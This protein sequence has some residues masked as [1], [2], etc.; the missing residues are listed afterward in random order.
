MNITYQEL[1][2]FLESLTP[3]QLAMNVSVYSGDIDEAM[4]VFATG[5]NTDEEMG[6]ALDTLDLGHPILLI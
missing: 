2:E 1:K 4:P 6:E 5:F 3:E